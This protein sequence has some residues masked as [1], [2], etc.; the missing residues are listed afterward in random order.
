MLVPA[1]VL[2]GAFGEARLGVLQ[3]VLL[4]LRNERVMDAVLAEDHDAALVCG[5]AHL[6]GMGRVL[7]CAGYELAA[8]VWRPA[9][10][11]RRIIDGIRTAR[12]LSASKDEWP[13]AGQEI[14]DAVPPSR[15]G[16]CC[17]SAAGSPTRLPP[18]RPP[19]R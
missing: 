3:R 17:A 5:T 19:H 13:W 11:R 4:D 6:P 9:M 16:H 14:P 7:A 8:R 1:L 15:R 10:A 12:N 18:E 2:A